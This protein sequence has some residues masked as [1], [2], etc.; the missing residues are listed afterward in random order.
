[1]STAAGLAGLFARPYLDLTPFIDTSIFPRVDD[2][3]CVG[4]AQLPLSMTGGSHRSMGIMPPSRA[5]EAHADYGEVL[6][7]LTPAELRDVAALGDEAPHDARE[8]GYG[9]ER[10]MPLSR[11]QL[12]FLKYR[13]GVYFPWS[14]YVELMPGGAWDEKAAEP[15]RFTREARRYFPLTVA[16]VESLPFEH[17]GSVKLLGLDAFQHGTVHRDHEPGPARA[18]DHFISFTPGR[19]KRIYLWDEARAA[20]TVIESRVY[21]FNDADYHGVEA[22]PFFRYSLR[23]DGVFRRDFVEK[24]RDAAAGAH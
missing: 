13:H 4:L 17:V 22:A 11:R 6:R 15:R 14:V 12:A 19:E 1:M 24:L 23:V 2:E 8:A 5:H 18:P 21:W 16:F 9:E 3:L 10:G 7:S 20:K